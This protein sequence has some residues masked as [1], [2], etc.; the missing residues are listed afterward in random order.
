M[1]K[2]PGAIVSSATML[3]AWRRVKDTPAIDENG[4]TKTSAQPEGLRLAKAKL[5]AQEC[6]ILQIDLGLIERSD[7]EAVA[8]S[9]TEN[10]AQKPFGRYPIPREV[11][12]IARARLAS[13]LLKF[14]Q[15]LAFFSARLV[16]ATPG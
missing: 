9:L 12:T 7:N 15:M 1:P 5:I 8:I 16:V 2:Q 14:M 3:P 13:S 10:Q 11:Q 4:R 6:A